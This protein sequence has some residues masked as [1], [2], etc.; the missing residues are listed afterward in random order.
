MPTIKTI[1][2]RVTTAAAAV[3][4]SAGLAAAEEK[5]LHVYNWVDYIGETTIA[6]FQNETGIKVVYDTYDASETV[7][8]KLLA[9]NS[10][11][12]VLIHA[13][14]FMPNLI[15]AGIFQE[16][17]KSKLPNIKHMDPDIMA[18]LEGWDPGNKFG[19]PYMWGT[20]GMTYNMTMIQERLPDGPY[21]SLDM[22]FKPELI[23]KIADCG[24]TI[25]DSPVDVIPMALAYLGKDPNSNDKEDLAAVVELFKPIREHIRTFD[26][27]QY[28]NTLPNSEQCAAMTWSGDYAT[29]T[30]RASEAGIDIDLQY[31][32]PE[33][34]FG[35]WFD[36]WAIPADAPHPENAHLWIDYM[37]RPEVIAAAT[38]YTY[39]ANANKAA[40]ELVS[41]DITGDPAIYP[42]ADLL[43]KM[44]TAKPPS[45][46]ELKRRTRAWTKIKTGQ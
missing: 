31:F 1:V 25:L 15:K 28:L 41:E 27:S 12:D 16:L 30:W 40:T 5:V 35:A 18:T 33:T 36:V 20:A 42:S 10:G 14:S 26:A 44:W 32:M 24:V 13:G 22:I 39:Y 6:D 4:L 7:D 2:S 23:S 34:G 45:A 8:A 19:V 9:G 17:D 3:A 29:A 21:G 37:M 38:N 43:S 11:Y 46:R